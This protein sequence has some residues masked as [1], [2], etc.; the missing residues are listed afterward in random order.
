VAVLII[1]GGGG[2]LAAL[3]GAYLRV[4][5]PRGLLRWLHLFAA[6][7]AAA[8]LAFCAVQAL[9]LTQLVVDTIEQGADR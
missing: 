2:I 9:D 1:A 4:A 5:S 6:V 3:S 8:S 7:A